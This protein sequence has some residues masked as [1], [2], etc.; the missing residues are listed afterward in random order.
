MISDNVE[1][2]F[3]KTRDSAIVPVRSTD[4]SGCYDLF[5]AEQVDLEPSMTEKIPLGFKV[6][7]PA[8]Y[9]L[10]IFPRSSFMMQGRN[11][12]GVVDSDYRGEVH[13]IIQNLG[14]P[15]CV[16][17]G[18]KIAQATLLRAPTVHWV[19]TTSLSDTARGVGGFGSTGL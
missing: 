19:E 11:A 2:K 9:M 12:I 18:M 4:G 7:I 17:K 16:T 14:L 8:G 1:V 10:I 5:A 6:E 3:V 13:V 15:F